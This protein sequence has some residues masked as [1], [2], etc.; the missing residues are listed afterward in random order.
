MQLNDSIINKRITKGMQLLGDAWTLQ[1]LEVLL[2]KNMRF[3]EIQR[4]INISPGMLANRLRK[5]E[6]TRMLKR[7]LS[8]ESKNSVHYELTDRGRGVRT[9]L[10]ALNE[11]ITLYM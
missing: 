8:T 5:L 9:V 7:Q 3:S 1:I 6:E 2:Q 11:F 4:E 10:E